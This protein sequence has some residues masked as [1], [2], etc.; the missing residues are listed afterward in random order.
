M[1]KPLIIRWTLLVVLLFSATVSL[2]SQEIDEPLIEVTTDSTVFLKVKYPLDLPARIADTIIAITI[3][4]MDSLNVDFINCDQYKASSVYYKDHLDTAL[5]AVEQRDSM[6]FDFVNI[7]KYQSAEIQ[8]QNWV[9]AT[10]ESNIEY[11]QKRL[12]QT[13]NEKKAFAIGGTTIATVLGLLWLL[14]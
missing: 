6:L 12:K 9:I 3:N 14:K 5:V 10:Q 11:L 4:Q 8:N 13:Q 1:K 2:L 7:N